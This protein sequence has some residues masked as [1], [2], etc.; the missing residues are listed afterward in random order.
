MIFRRSILSFA[1]LAVLALPL[2][3]CLVATDPTTGQVTVDPT[4]NPV[5]VPNV[6]TVSANTI[7][8][9]I[10]SVQE[11]TKLACGIIAQGKS[12]ADLFL[13]GNTTYQSITAISDALCQLAESKSATLR[14]RA[15]ATNG[16]IGYING[17]PIVLTARAGVSTRSVRSYSRTHHLNMVR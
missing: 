17:V 8:D 5:V 10:T 13:S 1:A 3:G 12:I 14:R 15:A 2:G 6:G 4:G 11:K 7:A 9:V 16:V